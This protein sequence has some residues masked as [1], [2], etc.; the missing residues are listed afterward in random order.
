[1]NELELEL[2]KLKGELKEVI[3]SMVYLE[4]EQRDIQARIIKINTILNPK[5]LKS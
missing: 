3:G 5:Q 2:K 4:M 1:M